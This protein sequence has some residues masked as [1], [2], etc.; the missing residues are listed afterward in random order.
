MDGQSTCKRTY[1]P[2][3]P[4]PAA[5]ERYE[6]EEQLAQLSSGWKSLCAC[7][8][9]AVKSLLPGNSHEKQD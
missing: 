4:T 6:K 8:V 1:T 5:A 9:A 3:L 7:W 2:N